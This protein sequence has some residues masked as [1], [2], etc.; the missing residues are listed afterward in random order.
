MEAYPLS[1]KELTLSRIKTQEDAISKLP[2]ALLRP[3]AESSFI[4]YEE[5]YK[6]AKELWQQGKEKQ[7]MALLLQLM[8]EHKR[9]VREGVECDKEK[10]RTLLHL[11]RDRKESLKSD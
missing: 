9:L 3:M 7:L 4:D 6:L 11:E 10:E 8:Q 1:V 2:F 5:K